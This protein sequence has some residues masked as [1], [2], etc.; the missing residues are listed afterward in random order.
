[1]LNYTELLLTT[2]ADMRVTLTGE[3]RDFVFT[4]HNPEW[5]GGDIVIT[6]DEG[7][8]YVDFCTMNVSFGN[9]FGELVETVDELIHDESMIFELYSHGEYVMGGSRG[10]DEIDID[11]SLRSFA[12]S[13]CDGSHALHAEIKS[14]VQEGQCYCKLRGWRKGRN[15]SMLLS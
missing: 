14:Y 13:L 10:T 4:I 2:Y 9:Q 1:M 15:R 8:L 5:E 7:R 11:G 6:C 3:G 12:R